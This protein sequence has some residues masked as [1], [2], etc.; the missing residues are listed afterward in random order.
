VNPLVVGSSPTGPTISRINGLAVCNTKN[1]PKPNL[2]P[3]SAITHKAD[4]S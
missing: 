1:L 4:D 2:I 3:Q